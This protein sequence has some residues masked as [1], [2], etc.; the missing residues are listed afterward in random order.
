MDA[1][2]IGPGATVVEHDE[3]G[4]SFH[5]DGCLLPRHAARGS[6][7]ILP[8]HTA[9]LV[10]RLER[11]SWFTHYGPRGT[12]KRTDM[13][14]AV[15]QV[16]REH[17]WLSLSLDFNF[18]AAVSMS[19]LPFEEQSKSF[20][21]SVGIYINLHLTCQSRA[22]GAGSGGAEPE[23]GGPAR[24][25]AAEWSSQDDFLAALRRDN[26]PAGT[27]LV[28]T[29]WSMHHMQHLHELTQRE[30]R[31]TRAQRRYRVTGCVQLSNRQVAA[32][33][34]VLSSSDVAQCQLA[35]LQPFF[36]ASAPRCFRFRR[37]CSLLTA[38]VAKASLTLAQAVL[39]SALIRS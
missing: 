27:R 24:V 28:L 10:E 18:A 3:C 17:G 19:S 25:Q 4:K 39:I 22:R 38:A 36:D 9:P 30:V 16:C 34:L 14:F 37:V 29:L 8:P 15:E 5:L 12:G 35:S 1:S 20:W 32:A 13:G 11:G 2:A 26:L 23:A 33:L 7:F 21:K 31:C 6:N